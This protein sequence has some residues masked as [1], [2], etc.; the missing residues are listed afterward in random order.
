MSLSI[1]N[2]L[3]PMQ[4]LASCTNSRSMGV[5]MRCAARML[6]ALCCVRCMY[7]CSR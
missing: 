1:V 6:C 7:S 2:A 3:G 4:W 5:C